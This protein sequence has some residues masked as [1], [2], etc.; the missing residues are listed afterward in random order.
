MRR[1]SKRC[2]SYSMPNRPPN[3]RAQAITDLDELIVATQFVASGV[4]Q[5]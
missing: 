4:T 1:R 2:L 3:T 5:R